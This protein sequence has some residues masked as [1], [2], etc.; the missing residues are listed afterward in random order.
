MT[1]SIPQQSPLQ[2]PRR[3]WILQHKT[4]LLILLI[5]I[6][7]IVIA[8]LIY[9]LRSGPI[10]TE[11]PHGKLDFSEGGPYLIGSFVELSENV[12]FK[13]VR[14]SITDKSVEATATLEP[15][16][17]N[18]VVQVPG[19]LNAS[20]FDANGNEQIDRADVIRPYN[21][22]RGDTFTFTYLPTGGIIVSYTVVS[23]P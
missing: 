9:P 19:G 16:V 21:W 4:S 14:F 11:T 20:Y 2:N 7:I 10:D 3:H 18:E 5:I 23:N 6:T 22:D 1:V 17:S 12:S 13:Y 8:G 15:L